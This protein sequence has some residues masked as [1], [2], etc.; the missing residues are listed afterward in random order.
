M[1]ELHLKKIPVTTQ[2]SLTKIPVTTQGTLAGK[3]Q[4]IEGDKRAE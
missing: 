4:E 3:R 1:S 2:G